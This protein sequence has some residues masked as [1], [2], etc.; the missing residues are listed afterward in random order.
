VSDT[1]PNILVF[2]PH[3]LGDTLHCCGHAQVRSPNLDRLAAGGVRFSNYF[4]ASPECSPS[5]A[6][7]MTGGHLHENGM[8]GLANFGWE[9]RWP[10]LAARLRDA[11]YATHLFGI[12][13]ETAQAAETLGYT[14]VHTTRAPETD[15]PL[16]AA[17]P[18]CADLRAFLEGAPAAPWFACAGFQEVHRPWP[19]ETSFSPDSMVVPPYLPDTP[20]IRL[21]LARFYENI[22]HMDAMVGEVLVA[23]RRSPAYENTLAIFTTDHGAG[24][25]RAKATLYDPGLRI[26]LIMHWPGRIEGGRV[27]DA[28]LS[29]VDFAPTMMELAGRRVAGR[30]F[31]PLL[32][33]EDYVWN[34][35][36]AASLFYDVAYDP[37]HAIRTRTHKYIRSFAVTPEEAAGADPRVLATH[38]AGQWVRVDDYDVLSSAAWRSMRAP[39]AMPSREELYDLRADPWEKH[40]LV[41][42]PAAADALREMRARLAD[43]MRR[44]GSPL[45]TGHVKPPPEQVKASAQYA[46]DGPVYRKQGLVP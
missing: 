29:N 14:H 46:V 5:R 13:H 34:D 42:D 35:A 25:P 44:T 20:A 30:G 8:M 16:R 18:V 9:L 1:Q 2:L 23:L 40:N 6:S 38:V 15:K 33:G 24:F 27:F 31:A 10:H 3:D 28:L 41:N 12:Q 22:L 19:E 7:M 11:G 17:A 39:Q 4:C 26:P 21:D 36:I 43:W 37:M 32:L 45:L